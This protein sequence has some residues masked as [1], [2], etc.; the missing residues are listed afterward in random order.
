[1]HK[2]PSHALAFPSLSPTD[3]SILYIRT[4]RKA[5]RELRHSA[6][7]ARLLTDRRSDIHMQQGV[8][9]PVNVEQRV[10]HSVLLYRLT[11]IGQENT[12]CFIFYIF[13]SYDNISSYLNKVLK[14]NKYVANAPNLEI[15]HTCLVFLFCYCILF[16]MII[17][18][19]GDGRIQAPNDRRLL[20]VLS[21]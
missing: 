13:A 5:F 14:K 6:E 4:K 3:N 15:A 7:Q 1:M 19:D 12:Y 21:F 2:H 17:A 18:M 16:L 10:L 11:Y 20:L 8:I 9:R